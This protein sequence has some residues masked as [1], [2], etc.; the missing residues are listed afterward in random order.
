MLASIILFDSLLLSLVTDWEPLMSPH[1]DGKYSSRKTQRFCFSLVFDILHE[2]VSIDKMVWSSLPTR[3]HHLHLIWITWSLK[4]WLSNM[5]VS[6]YPCK[7]ICFQPHHPWM[8]MLLY[9]TLHSCQIC[10]SFP[11]KIQH[12]LRSTTWEKSVGLDLSPF[13]KHQ[14]IP[15][16]L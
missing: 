2:H 11:L 9:S 12:L 14:N 13:Q 5:V 4:Q 16:I 7:K 8:T 3:A 10:D 6:G 15:L 1:V